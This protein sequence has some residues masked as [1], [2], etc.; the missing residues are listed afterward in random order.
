VCILQISS[1]I[2]FVNKPIVASPGRDY[3][4]TRM[5]LTNNLVLYMVRNDT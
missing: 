4:L 2:Y 3:V 5:V 1:L